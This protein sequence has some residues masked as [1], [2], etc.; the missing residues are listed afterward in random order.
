MVKQPSNPTLKKYGL[1]VAEWRV[2]LEKQNG[3]C[4]ICQKIP[5]T[6]RLCIDHF[7]IRGFKKMKPEQKKIYVRGLLCNYCNLRIASKAI[8]L[9]KA[10]RLVEYLQA[11]DTKLKNQK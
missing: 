4:F 9:E 8:N 11:F 2:L 6:E 10:I 1:S 5:K 3:V 7:H